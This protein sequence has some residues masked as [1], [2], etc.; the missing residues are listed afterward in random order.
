MF[1]PFTTRGRRTGS[2]LQHMAFDGIS[3]T[4]PQHDQRDGLIPNQFS[5]PQTNKK[6]SIN[7]ITYHPLVL[8]RVFEGRD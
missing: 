4:S 6:P 8:P 3:F 7:K 5:Y 1:H 2:I